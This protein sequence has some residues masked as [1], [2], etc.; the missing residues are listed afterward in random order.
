MPR[1][2]NN[3]KKNNKKNNIKKSNSKSDKSENTENKNEIKSIE[4]YE[5]K[6]K[7]CETKFNSKISLG[8]DIDNLVSSSLRKTNLFCE[9]HNKYIEKILIKKK[10]NDSR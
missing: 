1:R 10:Q 8:W 3:N 5:C 7:G 9:Y 4:N 2:T 6:F